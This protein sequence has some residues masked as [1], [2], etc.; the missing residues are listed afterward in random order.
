MMHKKSIWA[1]VAI[2]V[3]TFIL[4]SIF[5]LFL[6]FNKKTNWSE[7]FDSKNN[8]AFDISIFTNEIDSL[9]PH[10]KIN[11]YDTELDSYI[12][13]S[14]NPNITNQTIIVIKPYISLYYDTLIDYLEKGND[15]F[16]FSNDITIT[17]QTRKYYTIQSGSQLEFINPALKKYETKIPYDVQISSI[18]L[19]ASYNTEILG[20]ANNSPVFIR[21][22]IGNGNLY[23][24]NLPHVFSNHYLITNTS[25]YPSAILSYIKQNEVT[26]L[27]THLERYKNYNAGEKPYKKDTDPGILYFILSNKYLK[28][29][30]YL[31]LISSLVFILFRAK[32][33]Q[34]IVPIL[35]ENKNKTLEFIK[36]ISSIYYNEKNNLAMVKKL[37]QQFLDQVE[38]LYNIKTDELDERFIEK[39]A[40]L[41][42]TDITVVK[43]A[44]T[45]IKLYSYSVLQPTRA[46]I[47]E[48]Y[49]NL[50][51]II[52]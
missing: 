30:W 35:P 28:S 24:H 34:R 7:N 46:E 12:N 10:K 37:N 32:R 39:L 18:D 38:K 6:E 23:I 36:T 31:F 33:L 2:V 48:H 42:T 43:Q 1:I 19:S 11:K 20:K 13:S 9:L 49:L 22:K 5:Y 3:I 51:K 26:I 25:G 15:I 17:N 27:A 52:P 16:I 29:A 47:N 44:I 45:K 14:I 4:G 8:N 40:H 41:T 21:Y 50:K